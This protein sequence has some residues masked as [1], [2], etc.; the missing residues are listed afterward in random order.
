M[1]ALASRTYYRRGEANLYPG[2]TYT[3]FAVNVGGSWVPGVIMMAG[4][5]LAGP[6]HAQPAVLDT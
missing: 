2:G 1:T 3:D 4:E 6:T 5:I